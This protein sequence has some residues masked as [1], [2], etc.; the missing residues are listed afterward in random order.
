MRNLGEYTTIIPVRRE[1]PFLCEA[2]DSVL[3]QTSEPGPVLVVVNGEGEGESESAQVAAAYGGRV[4]VVSIGHAGIV[5][6]LNVGIQLSTTP[7]LAF[8]DSDDLWLPHKQEEQLDLLN[9]DSSLDAVRC[10]VTNFRDSPK[11]GRQVLAPREANMFVAITF[12]AAVFERFGR[13]DPR[14]SHHTWLYRWI[15]NAKKQGIRI[16]TTGEAGVMRR[17]HDHNSWI[18]EREKGQKELFLE[19]RRITRDRRSS[20]T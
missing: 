14:A 18:V 19:L 2:I 3:S 15:S 20:E 9:R 13:V 16:G 5:A 12:R 1:D 7:Y 10:K 6:A 17:V 11:A 4:N 8:L